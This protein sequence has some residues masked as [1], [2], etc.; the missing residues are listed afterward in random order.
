MASRGLAVVSVG[1]Q[2]GYGHA[3]DQNARESEMLSRNGCRGGWTYSQHC[4]AAIQ[5]E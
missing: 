3:I 2:S 1:F 5:V 4:R